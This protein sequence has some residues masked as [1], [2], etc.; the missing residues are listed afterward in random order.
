MIVMS[1]G[2]D[3]FVVCQAE[4]LETAFCLLK[5]GRAGTLAVVDFFLL[6]GAKDDELRGLWRAA[7]WLEMTAQRLWFKQVV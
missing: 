4:A 2:L 1:F 5:L 6:G 7:R 3:L